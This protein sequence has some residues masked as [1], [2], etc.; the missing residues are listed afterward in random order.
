V[1]AVCVYV[2]GSVLLSGLAAGAGYTLQA[3]LYDIG[4]VAR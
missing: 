1:V 3:L 2:F 4:L